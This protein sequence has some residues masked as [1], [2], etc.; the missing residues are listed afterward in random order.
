MGGVTLCLYFKFTF[1]I[2][3]VKIIIS[4]LGSLGQRYNYSVV[5]DGLWSSIVERDEGSYLL[6]SPTTSLLILKHCIYCFANL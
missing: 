4:S 6:L 5:C 2:T 1:N 3:K